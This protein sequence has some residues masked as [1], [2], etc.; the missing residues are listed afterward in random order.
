MTE[1]L[2]FTEK[3]CLYT[4]KLE[5]FLNFEPIT[6]SVWA[7]AS[8]V[9]RLRRK[10]SPFLSSLCPCVI[11]RHT[12]T[13]TGARPHAQTKEGNKNL[14]HK[15]E[16]SPGFESRWNVFYGFF[17]IFKDMYR[18]IR[19]VTRFKAINIDKKWKYLSNFPAVT[20][21]ALWKFFI[22]VIH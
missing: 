9:L 5:Y 10:F 1:K 15:P 18:M 3:K 21:Q 13:H 17:S 6:F 20:L 22:K 14:G 8:E 2:N 11:S 16:N 7:R 19:S 12:H 4:N